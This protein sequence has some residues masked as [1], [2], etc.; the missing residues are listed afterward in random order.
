MKLALFNEFIPGA[1]KENEI[2]DITKPVSALAK[3][4]P[5]YL[6]EGLMTNWA[7][8]RPLLE[9]YVSRTKGRPVSEV[10]LRAPLPRPS[11]ILCAAANYKEGIEGNISDLEFFH[12]SPS[13]I[14]GD[15]DT[16]I[17]PKV[18]VTIVHHELELG[19]VIGKT[20]KDVSE[21]EA[22]DYVF[23][24]TIVQD[25]SARGIL[26]NGQMSFFTQ[27]NW[28][29]FAPLGPLVVTKD[30]VRDPHDLQVRLWA[31]GELRQDYHTSDM[32]HRIP[33]LIHKASMFN[34]FF[35][36]DIIATGCNRQG[37]GPM[38]HGDTIVQEI[39]GLGRLTTLVEDPLKRSWPYGVDAEFA[40]FV[41]KP[42]TQRGALGPP[43][44][45]PAN[46]RLP[47]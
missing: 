19:V 22:L 4:G 39:T 33:A 34:T 17:L 7:T 14:I 31:N 38:Q 45:V 43:R 28:D 41:K 40:D 26:S 24:Y 5:Q 12:K 32:A 15:G 13:A 25:G 3:C 42:R 47:T 27:K 9:D 2:V 21:S 35:P 8:Y 29:T 37:L 44:I 36:G 11:K 46:S 10:R 20:C 30:E 6:M 16:M 18:E 1:I 23:G